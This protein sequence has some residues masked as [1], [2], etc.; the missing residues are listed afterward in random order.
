MMG[1]STQRQDTRIP[2]P[3]PMRDTVAAEQAWD[4]FGDELDAWSA[5]G[6][7]ASFWWRDDDAVAATPALDRLL[8]IAAVHDVPLALAVIP[9]P[10]EPSLFARLAEAPQAT[11]L[12]HGYA[13]RNHAPAGVKKCELGDERPAEAVLAELAR[14]RAL[15]DAATKGR[16]LPVLV[17]PWNRIGAAVEARLGEAGVKGLSTSKPRAGGRLDSGLVQANVHVDP[18][19]WPAQRRGDGGFAGDPAVLEATLRH[20]RARRSGTVDATEPTGFLTH[21]LVM[22]EATWRFAERFAATVARH[23]A[24]RWVAPATVFAD[25]A[26]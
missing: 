8:A 16:A 14:G 21:H 13:H 18:I 10:A 6:R 5:A 15:L 26:A 4:A 3:K 17:P 19:D 2:A 12:Q 7:T 23:P 11:V 25:D 1:L 9:V 24:A 22:D 20:L